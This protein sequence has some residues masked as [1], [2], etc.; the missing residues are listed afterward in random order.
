MHAIGGREIHRTPAVLRNL[1]SF[2]VA[3]CMV[4]TCNG[5]F[6]SGMT[7]TRC[8]IVQ[9]SDLPDG[10]YRVEFSGHSIRINKVRGQW[11]CELVFLTPRVQ[12]SKTPAPGRGLSS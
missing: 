6:S 7:Y 9:E 5:Y 4:E 2:R 10:P 3:G 11:E 8:R 1:E 12:S